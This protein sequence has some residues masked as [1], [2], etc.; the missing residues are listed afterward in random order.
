LFKPSP[1]SATSLSLLLTM[2][3]HR[4]AFD[5]WNEGSTPPPGQPDHSAKLS[6]PSNHSLRLFLSLNVLLVFLLIAYFARETKTEEKVKQRRRK[7]RNTV[8]LV[9][10]LASG[11]T[12]LF[13]KVR[14]LFLPS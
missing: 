6:T 14:W 10:P 5:L 11:K 12:A 4:K 2:S 3:L 13:S 9:G 8:L 1:S 7:G